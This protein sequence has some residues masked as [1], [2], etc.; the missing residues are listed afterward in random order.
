MGKDQTGIKT[1]DSAKDRA[2]TLVSPQRLRE[3]LTTAALLYVNGVFTLKRCQLGRHGF[4]IC[5]CQL[6]LLFKE[7]KVSS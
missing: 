1:R 5:K 4:M 6:H 3:Q 2:H 7:Q